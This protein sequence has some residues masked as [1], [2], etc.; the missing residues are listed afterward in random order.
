MVL[1]KVDGAWYKSRQHGRVLWKGNQN[2]KGNLKSRARVDGNGCQR[3]C[4]GVGRKETKM[5]LGTASLGGRFGLE[6]PPFEG[7]YIFPQHTVRDIE[8]RGELRGPDLS[9]SQR[10]CGR[11]DD[12]YNARPRA[13]K[14]ILRYLGAT[15][16]LY[17]VPMALAS[18]NCVHAPLIFRGL[19]CTAV[20]ITMPQNRW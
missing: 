3:Q 18:S 11:R 5:C 16:L 2:A 20:A 14:P 9:A 8:T 15:K 6:T 19:K 13:V 10:R 12:I 17:L 7:G 4:R 1:R